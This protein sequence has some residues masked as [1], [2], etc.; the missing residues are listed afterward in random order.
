VADVAIDDS[1]TEGHLMAARPTT[2]DL[3]SV[4]EYLRIEEQ[5]DIRHEYVGGLMHAMTG[6]SDEHNYVGGNF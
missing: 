3:I 2:N 5:S 1:I 6:G 4:E